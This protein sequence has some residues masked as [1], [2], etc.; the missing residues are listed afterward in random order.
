MELSFSMVGLGGRA[1]ET[2]C[3]TLRRQDQRQAPMIARMD[4]DGLL[5]P[6]SPISRED[7]PRTGGKVQLAARMER[8]REEG[9]SSPHFRIAP[10]RVTEV[11]CPR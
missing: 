8:N 10:K 2:D 11:V 6:L 1:V 3:T 7:D 4:P 9:L 5:C